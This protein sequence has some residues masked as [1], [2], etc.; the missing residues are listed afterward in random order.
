VTTEPRSEEPVRG[1]VDALR[2]GA[3]LLAVGVMTV[4]VP[5]TVS[6]LLQGGDTPWWFSLPVTAL[7][8]LGVALAGAAAAS[9]VRTTRLAARVHTGTVLAATLLL[10][11][12]TD[13]TYADRMPPWVHA[14]LPSA[15]AASVLVSRHWLLNLGLGWTLMAA[16]LRLRAEVWPVPAARIANDLL[17][18]MT[19]LVVAAA[20]FTSIALAQ[21]GLEREARATAQRFV[22]ARAT[23]QLG[24]RSAQWDALVHD[25]ILAALETIA[26]AP[27]D[28]DERALA[29]ATIE[30]LGEGPPVG[31]VDHVGFRAS[32]LEAV[33]AECPTAS[34]RF[35]ATPDA[36]VLPPDVAEA[37]LMAVTE[38]LRNAATH[39]YDADDPSRGAVT[40]RLNHGPSR[41]ALEV[42]DQGRGFDRARVGPT[43]FGLA[44]SIEGRVGA[45]G[46]LATISSRPG[47]GTTVRMQWPVGD[48]T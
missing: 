47:S 41:V 30:G 24:R 27:P 22:V 11:A 46:G 18:E 32:V 4:A 34:S 28:V 6:L 21:Q 15:I 17:F 44:L 20:V 40:V 10:P 31:D 36:R 12:V 33:L 29:R 45:V 35:A 14:Y 19:V 39:A 43:S 37:L 38:A 5:A 9:G 16:D 2:I 23:E 42:S 1:G 3:I 48:R 8:G 26:I 13:T 7:V 25:E